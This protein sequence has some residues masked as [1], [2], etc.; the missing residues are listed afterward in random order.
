MTHAVCVDGIFMFNVQVQHVAPA[1]DV[2]EACITGIFQPSVCAI[3]TPS[4][5]ETFEHHTKFFVGFLICF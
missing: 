5:Y 4:Y 1:E 3:Y 2:F